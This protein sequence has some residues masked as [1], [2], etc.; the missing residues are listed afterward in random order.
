MVN[1]FSLKNQLTKFL[2]FATLGEMY[3]D[4]KVNIFDIETYEKNTEIK[5]E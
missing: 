5:P 4:A 1:I 3:S 2:K